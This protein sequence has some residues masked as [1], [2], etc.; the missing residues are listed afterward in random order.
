VEGG[1]IGGG[2]GTDDLIIAE[3]IEG[4]SYNK[5]LELYNASSAAIDLTKY[6]LKL[7]DNGKTTA[8]GIAKLTKLLVSQHL[9]PAGL[10]Y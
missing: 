8:D 2:N 3:Y 7:Y 10:S 9:M 1:T 4:S 5:Y 6:T